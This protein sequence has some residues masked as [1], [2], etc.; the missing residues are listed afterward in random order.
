MKTAVMPLL[1]AILVTA[2]VLQADVLRLKQGEAV[3]GVLVTA[4]SREVVL[5]LPNGAERVYPSSAVAGIDFAPLVLPPAPKPAP[6][7]TA[8]V[9]AIPAGTQVAVRMVDAINGKTAQPGARYRATVDDPVGI[10]SQTVIPRG[11]N[12]IVE[13]VSLQAGQEMA[14]R[15]REINVAGK[16]YSTSTEY[17]EVQASGTSKQKS[18]LRRGVGLGALGAGIGALAGGG[19]GAEAGAAA[20]AGV[21]AVSA[22]GAKGKQINVPTET[23][24]IFAL[25]APLPM[26]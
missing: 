2:C 21:G 12:C 3:Q 24:L 16:A 19:K 7:P 23:R 13:V 25:S 20:G 9:P 22:V 4:N 11:A 6:A 18:A 14:L 5:M 17:A 8:G 15:L 10:G 26:I 1:G